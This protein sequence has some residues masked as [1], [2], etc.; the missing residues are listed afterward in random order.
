TG[1]HVALENILFRSFLCLL[2]KG[3]FDLNGLDHLG[4]GPLSYAVMSGNLEAVE[5]LLHLGANPDHE[6]SPQKIGLAA[7]TPLACAAAQGDYAVIEA[8]LDKHAQ[9]D[10]RDRHGRTALMF[11]ATA[12]S[13]AATRLLLSRGSQADRVDNENRTPLSFASEAGS[14]AV[15][16]LLLKQ[17]VEVDSKDKSLTTPLMYAAVSGSE[18][19]VSIL[20][21]RGAD[22]D[23]KNLRGETPL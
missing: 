8:L 20:A 11:A 9:I 2:E 17:I 16:S 23:S 19:V 7:L 13:G 18:S 21:S 3:Q 15:V 12:T 22:V 1:L 6:D 4:R 10:L 5:K 14:D